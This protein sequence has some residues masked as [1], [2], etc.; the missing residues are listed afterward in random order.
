MIDN[1]LDGVIADIR[2]RSKK[3][4]YLTDIKLW[5]KE[6]LGK[7]LWSKQEEIARSIVENTHTAVVSC[8]GAGKSGLAGIVAVWW[9][10]V[11]DPRE[12]AVIC[13]APTYV[14]IARVLFKEIQDNFSLAKE[15]RK[16][17]V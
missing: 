3:T 14:Q 2:A 1:V 12:V 17:V 15:D 16:S 13:S 10:A 9:V 11:H 6:V 8:N 5:A 4:E 7:T